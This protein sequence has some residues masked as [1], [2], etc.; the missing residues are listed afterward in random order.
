[1]AFIQFLETMSEVGRNGISEKD[2]DEWFW[3]CDDENIQHYGLFIVFFR[4]NV[5]KMFVKQNE[6]TMWIE[7]N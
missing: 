2:C 4:G 3:Q 7:C 5:T 1:M 6:I